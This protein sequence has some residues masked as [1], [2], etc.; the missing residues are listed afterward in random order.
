MTY[1]GKTF[2]DTITL[3]DKTDNYQADIESSGGNIFKNTQ[4]T[5][6]LICRLF[7]NGS[8]VDAVKSSVCSTSA[9]ASP[10]TGAYYYKVTTAAPT[11]ALM[12]Y[13]GSAWVDVTADATYGHSK[14]YT[15]YRRDKSGNPL[16]SG[17]AFATGK[18]IYVD[19]D[20]VAEKTTFICEVS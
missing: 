7:Q 3:T 15:W 4:G 19:G 12:R 8:E 5:S 16:D 11:T 10:T 17:A 6:H 13:S 2:T 18:V 20:D 14:T 1:G 9:P